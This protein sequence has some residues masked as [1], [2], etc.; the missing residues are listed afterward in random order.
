M[1]LFITDTKNIHCEVS[2]E[3]ELILWRQSSENALT[4]Q[5]V[6]RSYERQET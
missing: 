6:R 1:G 5:M 4:F 2:L 3:D